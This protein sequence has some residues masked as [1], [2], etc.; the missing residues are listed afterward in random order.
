M[1]ALVYMYK[2]TR[3]S[4]R[5]SVGG[6]Y[7]TDREFGVALF[8]A[9]HHVNR[10]VHDGK[11]LYI[12]EHPLMLELVSPGEAYAGDTIAKGPWPDIWD[13]FVAHVHMR[14]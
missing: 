4:P 8:T 6:A 11:L 3:G 2:N 13:T 12:Q 14:M 7:C 9:W 10:I 5:L 1:T